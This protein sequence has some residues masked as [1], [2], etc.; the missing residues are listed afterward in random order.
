VI[1]WLAPLFRVSI[2]AAG[3]PVAADTPLASD[4][5]NPAAPKTGTTLQ[6]GFRLEPSFSRDI[7]VSLRPTATIRQ[8]LLHLRVG[9]LSWRAENGPP[10]RERTEVALASA[11]FVGCG[12]RSAGQQ[13]RI[14]HLDDAV[15]LQDVADG[16]LRHIAF[17]VD[18]PQLAVI[19]FDGE[20][21]A[22]HRLEFGHAAAFLNFL[23]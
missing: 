8:R 15:R 12:K 9:Y 2:S 16:D 13:D 3:P 5:D 22:F 1:S 19:L 20:R 18:Q 10:P 17:G 23:T 11:V 4:N 7:I 21:F 14:N 6:P